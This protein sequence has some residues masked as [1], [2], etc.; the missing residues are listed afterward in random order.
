MQPCSD[1]ASCLE[2]GHVHSTTLPHHHPLQVYPERMAA[3]PPCTFQTLL[4]TLQFGVGATGDEEVTQSVFEA[5][6]ALARYHVRAVA[7]GSPGLGPNNAPGERRAAPS[8]LQAAA[9]AACMH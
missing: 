6:A 4:S 8:Q 2:R 9:A 5:A 3:L 7:A 1:L